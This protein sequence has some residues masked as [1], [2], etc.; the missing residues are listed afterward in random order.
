MNLEDVVKTVVRDFMN[1]GTLFTAL[2]ASNAV[3]VMLPQAR[4]G[5]VRDVVRNLFVTELVPAGWDRTNITVTLMD[6]TKQ[7]AL[8]YFP[9]SASW[10]L[11]TLYN[12]QKRTQ[13]SFKSPSVV[14]VPA[15]VGGDGTISIKSTSQLPVVAAAPVNPATRDLWK[16]MFTS[17]P[18]LFPR[19]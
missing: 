14:A 8:L 16:Q 7:T 19:K 1:N 2:D 12:D 10:N 3:K 5:E 6:G 18:S 17:Q 4:H 15:V 13:T 9:M 11:D